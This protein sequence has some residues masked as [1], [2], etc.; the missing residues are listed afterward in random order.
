MP[1]KK[2]QRRGPT[3]EARELV[4]RL[5]A[6]WRA[7][8]SK[9]EQPVIIEEGGGANRPMHVYVVWDEWGDL[10]QVERSTIIMDA[11]EERY[12]EAKSLNV[13]AAMGLTPGE[14]GRMGIEY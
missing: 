14:A 8:D 12:G 5:V 6:E 13:T 3:P 7:K 11:F 1:V 10:S 9:A 4:K 2:M